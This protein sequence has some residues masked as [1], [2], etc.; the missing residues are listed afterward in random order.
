[1]NFPPPGLLSSLHRYTHFSSP[2]IYSLSV[3]QRR[4]CKRNHT[5]TQ[6]LSSLFTIDGSEYI[7]HQL[8][9]LHCWRQDLAWSSRIQYGVHRQII[10]SGWSVVRLR[11]ECW[12]NM[13]FSL[14]IWRRWGNCNCNWRRMHRVMVLLHL[15]SLW[16]H[17]ILYPQAQRLTQVLAIPMS[18]F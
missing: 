9:F 7:Q 12:W 4:I 17:P 1:M 15:P 13:N 6:H 18:I 2:Q 10:M 5:A 8:L 3:L 14:R 11:T 16:R